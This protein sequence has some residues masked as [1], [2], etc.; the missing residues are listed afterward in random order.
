MDTEI[1]REEVARLLEI[2]KDAQT[3]YWSALTDLE[4]ACGGDINGTDDLEGYDVDG[5]L[6]E[7]EK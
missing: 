4:A 2:A 1:D 5:I 6:A 7:V 3:A